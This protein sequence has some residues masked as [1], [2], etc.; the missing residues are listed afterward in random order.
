MKIAPLVLSFAFF[1]CTTDLGLDPYSDP[2]LEHDA[3]LAAV[4]SDTT[5]ETPAVDLASIEAM[6]GGNVQALAKA[7]CTRQR[8]VHFANFS[9]VAELGCVNGVCPNGCW[10]Y[11]RR[12]SGFSCDYDATASDFVKTT[13]GTGPF[14]SYNEIKS[15]NPRDAAAVANCR[16]QSGNRP[17]RTYTVWNGSGWDSEGIPASLQFAE[18]FGT[19]TEGASRFAPW[20]SSWRGQFAP[21]ANVSPETGITFAGTKQT[22]AKICAAT[23]NGWL[24]LYFYDGQASGGPGMADWKREAIVSAMNYC[25]TH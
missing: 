19:Q 6:S 14:A 4:L 21:M 24:G 5:P 7:S 18:L 15:L 9:F 2:D 22:V 12:T 17:M 25:T 1:G 11:Q 8:F 16:A 23:R 20:F 10:G 3:E 13:T